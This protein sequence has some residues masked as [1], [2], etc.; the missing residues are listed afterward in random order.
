MAQHAA[1]RM[2]VQ[3]KTWCDT[4]RC[5]TRQQYAEWKS[6]LHQSLGRGEVL[7]ICDD[8]TP[9]YEA[10]QRALQRCE[11]SAWSDFVFG[12]LNKRFPEGVSPLC[13]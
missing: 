8:C 6:L 12:K 7:R 1:R 13:N 4:P 5:F 3:P 2:C 10:Q 11:K 9:A